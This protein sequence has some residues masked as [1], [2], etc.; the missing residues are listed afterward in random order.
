MQAEPATEADR[1]R[2]DKRRR[3][4]DCV[5]RRP[6]DR[7]RERPCAP[8]EDA[9]VLRLADGAMRVPPGC[10]RLLARIGAE[11]NEGEARW[12]ATLPSS[13]AA[14]VAT[15]PPSERRS[16]APRPS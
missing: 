15:Q 6:P 4:P 16:S 13:G 7:L 11:P 1:W 5:S 10:R 3:L 8:L 2:T 9:W 14:R 12:S